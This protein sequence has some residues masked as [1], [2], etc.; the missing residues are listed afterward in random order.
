MDPRSQRWLKT[1]K[2][3]SARVLGSG[4]RSNSS[5]ISTF[6]RDSCRCRLGRRLSSRAFINSCTRAAVVK[7]TDMPHWQSANPSPGNVEGVGYNLTVDE[8]KKQLNFLQSAGVPFSP[9]PTYY[10]SGIF[11]SKV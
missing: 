7:P 6:S 8:L 5:M 11:D 9:T 4:T 10:K 2:R 3:S 1:S